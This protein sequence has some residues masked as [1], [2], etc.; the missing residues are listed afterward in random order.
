LVDIKLFAEL[1]RIEYALLYNHSV[2]EALAWCGENRG[3]LKKTKVSYLL[4]MRAIA[5]D[6]N[7]LEFT[8]RM[9]EYIELCRQ[10]KVPE[11][12]VYSRKNLAPWA[13]THLVEL[14]Q[15]MTLLAFGEK[16][17]VALYRV[18]PLHLPQY[19]ADL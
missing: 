8:L 10:R 16:S 13:A 17:G 19:C 5:D 7:N 18:S 2:T 11:A 15:A 3:T 12:I 9:Q 4:T 1:S 6:Q 14:Q